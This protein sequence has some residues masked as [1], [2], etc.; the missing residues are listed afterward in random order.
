M[1]FCGLDTVACPFCCF[2]SVPTELLQTHA[3]Y[4]FSISGISSGYRLS[5]FAIT[6]VISFTRHQFLSTLK[7]DTQPPNDPNRNNNNHNHDAK[8]SKSIGTNNDN[9][10][11]AP[12]DIMGDLNE[13]PAV[14]VMFVLGVV[15]WLLRERCVC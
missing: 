15:A 12:M 11:D 9:P 1:A 4:T 10:N 13:A 3:L 8:H 7:M 14:V 5:F 2:F 6:A